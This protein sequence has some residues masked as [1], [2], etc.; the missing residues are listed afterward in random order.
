MVMLLAAVLENLVERLV[1][2]LEAVDPTASHRVLE[3]VGFT[4]QQAL[5]R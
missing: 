3:D 2:G 5:E 1:T 4:Q